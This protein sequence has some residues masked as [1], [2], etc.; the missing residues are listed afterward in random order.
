MK[1]FLFIIAALPGGGKG[2]QGQILS[3]KLSANYFA[4]GDLIR[5]IISSDGQ[6]SAE[7]KIRYDQGMPQPDDV[8]DEIFKQTI[9]K[10]LNE[11]GNKKFII[12]GYPRSLSQAKKLDIL[13]DQLNLAKPYY[14]YL[15]VKSETA[16]NRIAKRLFCNSC[17][18]SYLPGQTE[19]IKTA[20]SRCGKQ[21]SVRDQDK[22]EIAKIRISKEK[23]II[24]DLVKYYQK[25]NRLLTVNG[26]PDIS[27]I[28]NNIISL[29]TDKGLI[30]ND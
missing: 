18:L 14:I 17:G 28:N 27:S 11:S 19:Y 9:V 8:I 22:P 7:V 5:Q 13:S 2:S 30:S 10:Y 15:K 1:D 23:V 16:L 25:N 4:T 6:L 12:D 24:D 29:L 3:K 20:C 26:E 21:I